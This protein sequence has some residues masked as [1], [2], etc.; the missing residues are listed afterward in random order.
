MNRRNFM[1][2]MG[3]AALPVARFV[4]YVRFAPAIAVPARIALYDRALPQGDALA[5][6]AA[7]AAIPSLALQDDIGALWQAQ[8]A[9]RVRAPV[10]A[11]CALRASDRFVIERLATQ[12]GITVI[13]IKTISDP[14]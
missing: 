14:D 9:G 4:R 2:S 10:I 5:R 1:V 8:M 7:L 12:Q 11:L 13:D 3:A 6:Y